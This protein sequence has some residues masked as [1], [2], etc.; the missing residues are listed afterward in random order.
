MAFHLMEYVA[1]AGPP[2]QILT[3][4][5]NQ[6]VTE[7]ISHI[8]T[9]PILTAGYNPQTIGKVEKFNDTLII[10]LRKN[11]ENNTDN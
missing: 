3:E 2:K 11:C 1:I 4:W 10:L 8:G 6:I 7:L 5:C 9:D